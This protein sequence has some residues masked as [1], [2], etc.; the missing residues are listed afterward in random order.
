MQDLTNSLNHL[1]Q[2]GRHSDVVLKATESSVTPLNS[3]EASRILAASLFCLSEYEKAY[4]ILKEIESVFYDNPQYLSLFGACLRRLGDYEQ[5]EI[6]L[7]RALAVE[8]NSLPIRNNF[9]NLMIDMKKY[10]Q[11]SSILDGILLESPSFK[12][13]IVNKNRLA[14]ISKSSDYDSRLTKTEPSIQVNTLSDPLLLAF[15]QEEIIY[16]NSR[17][18]PENLVKSSSTIPNLSKSNERDVALDQLNFADAAIING[19]YKLVLKLCSQCMRILGPDPRIFDYASDAYLNLKQLKQSEIC[20]LNAICLGGLTL[21]RC[22]NMVSFCMIRSNLSL[23]EYYLDK[24]ASLDPSS[25]DLHRLRA[26]L[27]KKIE[28]T[29]RPYVF[30]QVWPE[31]PMNKKEI[32]V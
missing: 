10:D 24:A 31:S 22:F 23:A 5:S 7:K 6:L 9:A 26:I 13:A 16:S 19:D 2:A 14:E 17:Y 12:D 25:S 15:E 30:T 4:Q 20:L 18:F 11:A 27:K 8:P 28:E 1:F 3:P 29:T 21:K 32:N